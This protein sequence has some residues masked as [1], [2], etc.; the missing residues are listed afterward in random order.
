MTIPKPAVAVI[1]VAA[2]LLG[3]AIGLRVFALL[4]GA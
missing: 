1:M 2:L 4:V 3:V